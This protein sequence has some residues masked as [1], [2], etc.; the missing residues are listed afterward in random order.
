VK[1]LFPL[2]LPSTEWSEFSTQG[3]SIRVSGVIYHGSQPPVCGVP[4]GGI[5]TGC[6]DLEA[7]GLFGYSMIF[8]SLI[9]RRGPLNLPF[10]GVSVGGLTLT[11]TG[12]SPASRRLPW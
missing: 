6:L 11:G 5:D 2:D 8:N 1:T 10:L 9:P 3:F 4:L 12:L 7:N